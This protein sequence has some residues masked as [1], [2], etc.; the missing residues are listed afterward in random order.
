VGSNAAALELD[1][2]IIL[3][4]EGIVNTPITLVR[5]TKSNATAEFPL[6]AFANATQV[7]NVVGAQQNT[8]IPIFASYDRNGACINGNPTI[9]VMKSMDKTPYSIAFGDLNAAATCPH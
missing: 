6:H 7:D 3:N 8:T 1:P 4:M 5:I 2:K 9:G